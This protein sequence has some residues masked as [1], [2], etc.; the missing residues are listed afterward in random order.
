MG[1]AKTRLLLLLLSLS[2]ACGSLAQSLSPGDIAI[3]GLNSDNPDAMVFLTLADLPAG[4]SISFTDHG[5]LAT[6][7]FR[8]NEGVNRYT[9]STAIPVGRIVVLNDFGSGRGDFGNANGPP[10][11]STSGDQII[12]FQGTVDNPTPIYAINFDGQGEWHNDASSAQTSA[13]P[14]GLSNGVTAVAV[15]ECD[16][17]I[18]RGTLAGD[19]TS[20]LASIGDKGNWECSNSLRYDFRREF[21]FNAPPALTST[22]SDS[23]LVPGSAFDFRFEAWDEDGDDL[24]WA[25]SP[26]PPPGGTFDPVAARLIWTPTLSDDGYEQDFE[27]SASDGIAAATGQFT[28][29][30]TAPANLSPQFLNLATDTLVVVGISLRLVIRAEDPEGQPVSVELFGMPPGASYDGGTGQFLWTPAKPGIEELSVVASDGFNTVTRVIRIGVTGSINPGIS[31]TALAVALRD[32]FTPMVTLSESASR[33]S[34]F[35]VVESDAGTVRGLYTGL[36]ASLLGGDPS[37]DAFG[38]GLNTEHLWPRSRG[39]G[40]YPANSDLYILYPAR[41]VVNGARGNKPFGE[42]PATSALAWYRLDQTLTTPPP[43]SDHGEYSRSGAD[44][45][46]PRASVKGD[47]ARA[48]LYFDLIHA[49]TRD[50]SFFATQLPDLLNWHEEDPIDFGE[51]QRG[52]RIRRLQG[53]LNPFVLDPSLPDRLYSTNT[54]TG[55]FPTYQGGLDFV[56]WPHPISGG[57]ADIRVEGFSRDSITIEVFDLMGRR[58]KTENRPVITAAKATISLGQAAPGVYLLRLSDGRQSITRPVVNL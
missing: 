58:I 46:Q 41:E 8:E 9:T 44:R 20:V 13:L 25:I 42:V 14:A 53:N 43:A 16:N 2:W 56:V 33:D 37:Q 7:G 54:S 55:E 11:L 18:Y 15:E 30:V 35:A 19:R 52:L 36:P 23:T 22:L 1:R 12:A 48:M 17:I 51:M 27:V 3:V 26:A 32:S 49:A 50:S 38:Q 6:G 45:F 34:M 4:T 24:V 28:L 57:K 10:S 29:R 5:W 40:E 39:A 31:G 47:V 21:G